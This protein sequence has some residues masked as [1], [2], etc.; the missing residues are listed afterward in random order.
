MP[1]ILSC[2]MAGLWEFGH[3]MCIFTWRSFGQWRRTDFCEAEA[4]CLMQQE[5]YVAVKGRQGFEFVSGVGGFASPFC[6]VALQN[7]V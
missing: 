2:R 5:S 7:V 4:K 1:G 6:F 3:G